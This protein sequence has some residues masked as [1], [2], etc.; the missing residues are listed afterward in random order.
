MK[1]TVNYKLNKPEP[2]D[3]VDIEKLNENMDTLDE[4][5]K[6]VSDKVDGQTNYVHPK[7]H[8][9][10]MITTDS[11]KQ[12]VSGEEKEAWNSIANYK[13][14][15]VIKASENLNNYKT[16][17][18]YRALTSSVATSLYNCP[19]KDIFNLFVSE[20]GSRLI[21]V[22]IEKKTIYIRDYTGAGWNAWEEI[23]NKTRT[24]EMIMAALGAYAK[25]DELKSHIEDEMPHRFTDGS[26]VYKYGFKAVNGNLQFN[27]EEV[28]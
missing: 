16:S 14:P 23:P 24:G 12:F 21:Q 10:S 15:G 9:A 1:Q 18:F 28:R 8:P 4:N 6:S 7:T 17:G 5:L 3:Y 13:D 2:S 22:L 27:Y 26:V 25:G 11:S 20:H 19:C